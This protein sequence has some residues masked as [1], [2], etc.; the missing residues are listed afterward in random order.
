LKEG[1]LVMPI[2]VPFVC[3][4]ALGYPNC[5]I[6]LIG[7]GAFRVSDHYAESPE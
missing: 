1:L 5:L 7:N 6:L 2:F 4:V 3:V